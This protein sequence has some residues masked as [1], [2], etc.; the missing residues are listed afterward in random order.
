M[1]ETHSGPLGGSLVTWAPGNVVPPWSNSGEWILGC[2]VALRES[3]RQ[4]ETKRQ[5]S[6]GTVHK[7]TGILSHKR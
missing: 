5:S 7:F 2:A 6:G 4:C 3:T 1:P